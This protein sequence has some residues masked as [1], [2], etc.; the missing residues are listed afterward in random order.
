MADGNPHYTALEKL[1]SGHPHGPD[2]GAVEEIVAAV[3]KMVEY[4]NYPFVVMVQPDAC[5]D[6]YYHPWVH[7]RFASRAE[8]DHFCA[9]NIYVHPD[10][11]SYRAKYEVREV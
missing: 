5:E 4:E 8:A 10:F 6:D 7:Q 11:P 3:Y 9:T 1:V 2:A